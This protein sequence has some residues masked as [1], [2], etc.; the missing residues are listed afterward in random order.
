MSKRLPCFRVDD[1][2]RRDFV[3]KEDAWDT[4]RSMRDVCSNFIVLLRTL[5][6]VSAE[7]GGTVLMS[8]NLC[9]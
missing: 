5:G 9:K 4:G 2:N 3:V 7:L 6:E 1:K 8:V